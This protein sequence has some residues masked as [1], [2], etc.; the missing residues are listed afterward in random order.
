MR[1]K[2][3]ETRICLECG[4]SFLFLNSPSRES[5]GRF[6]SKSCGVAFN[7]RSH[8][9]SG[10]TSSSRTYN[11]WAQM[12]ARCSNPNLPNFPRYGGRGITV[13]ERWNSFQNFLADMGERPDGMT[14]DRKDNDGPY[15][16]ENCEWKTVKHQ[17]RNRRNNVNV[18]FNGRTQ[19]ASDWADELGIGRNTLMY[20]L[21]HWPIDRALTPILRAAA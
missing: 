8:G 16:K 6:C 2:P 14:L 18:T 17:Q 1:K 4:D 10:H 21:K 3:R 15:C 9:H 20:R 5:R 13:C 11:T 19:C 7:Q 12:R